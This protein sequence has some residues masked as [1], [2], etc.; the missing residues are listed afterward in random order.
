LRDMKW[1]LNSLWHGGHGGYGRIPRWF[2]PPPLGWRPSC[3]GLYVRCVLRHVLLRRR[4]VLLR[5]GLWRIALCWAL[6][7]ALG[8]IRL[9]LRCVALGRILL[10]LTKASFGDRVAASLR[11]EPS[12]LLLLP[13]STNESRCF[14]SLAKTGR[15]GSR[16]G[17]AAISKGLCGWICSLGLVFF[18]QSNVWLPLPRASQGVLTETPRSK[19]I[20]AHVWN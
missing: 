6:R 11:S 8:R 10:G 7:R 20:R 15:V 16:R 19:P 5:R 14:S 17:K 2:E 4:W 18:D 13:L 9:R 12:S 1:D 3:L